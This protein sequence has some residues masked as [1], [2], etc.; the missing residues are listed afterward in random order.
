MLNPMFLIALT[1]FLYA[2]D[3][4][5]FLQP[6][7]QADERA[8]YVDYIV[9]RSGSG[10]GAVSV[11]V[12]ASGAGATLGVDYSAPQPVTLQWIG[13]DLAPKMVR[14]PLLHNPAFSYGCHLT[15]TLANAVGATVTPAASQVNLSVADA[16]SDPAGAL[17]I[18]ADDAQGH[19]ATTDDQG[20]LPLRVLRSGGLAGVQ[21]ITFGLADY[22]SQAGVDYAIPGGT[23]LSWADGE[24]G[25]KTLD[26]GILSRA[27]A[28]GTRTLYVLRS[29]STTIPVG[30][31]WTVAIAD[32]LPALAG[33]L[34]VPASV[35]AL[36]SAGS[37]AVTVGR[38]GGGSG[39]VSVQ[40]AIVDDLMRDDTAQVGVNY[41]A[42]SGT[43]TWTDGDMA[44]KTVSIPLLGDGVPRPTLSSCIAFSN[45]TGGLLIAASPINGNPQPGQAGCMLNILDDDDQGLLGFVTTSALVDELAGSVAFQVTR[46]N[47]SSGAI[48]VQWNTSSS[49]ASAAIA[50][51]DFIASGGT[52]SWA[53]GDAS[54]RTITVPI[55]HQAGTQLDRWFWIGLHTP[56]GGAGLDDGTPP[57]RG[58]TVTIRD[59]DGGALDS[60]APVAT[61]TSVVESAGHV[62]VDFVRSGNGVGPASV[63]I[64]VAAGSAL[65]VLQY[66][67]PSATTLTWADGEMGVKSLE[68]PIVANGVVLPADFTVSAGVAYGNATVALPNS[69]TVTIQDDSGTAAPSAVSNGDDGC[70]GGLTGIVLIALLSCAMWSRHR[71]P[72]A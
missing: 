22:D 71:S 67:R 50:G 26:L 40:W 54:A 34:V 14:L 16:E 21:S 51:T 64:L 1:T 20:T 72:V 7:Q 61:S 46:S 33:I 44:D 38:S 5:G 31:G 37:A 30:D 59:V 3:A 12:V 58:A 69:T 65:P 35:S 47:G 24:G 43:L 68:I 42:V 36:E 19:V 66:G 4:V 23:T 63:Q 10:A 56:T 11:D 32:H 13:G 48:S 17:V 25:V 28:R 8:G 52:L 57:R 53:N 15:L 18:L 27:V 55:L 49:G 2:G 45:P 60:I 70:G 41:S 9:T 6:Q 39:A 29:N 62:S